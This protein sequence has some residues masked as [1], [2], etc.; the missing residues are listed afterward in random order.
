MQYSTFEK[1]THKQQESLPPQEYS[2]LVVTLQRNS[3]CSFV[4]TIDLRTNNN[5]HERVVDQGYLR[6]LTSVNFIIQLPSKM[7]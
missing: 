1:Q 3:E 7:N 5:G 6:L 2:M 4:M